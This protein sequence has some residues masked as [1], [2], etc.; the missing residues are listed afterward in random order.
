MTQNR[1]TKQKELETFHSTTGVYRL[2]TSSV[3]LAHQASIYSIIQSIQSFNLLNVSPE[4]SDKNLKL[5]EWVGY[6]WYSEGRP[7]QSHY[8]TH[9]FKTLLGRDTTGQWR[10]CGETQWIANGRHIPLNKGRQSLQ[11]GST[12]LCLSEEVSGWQLDHV[13][14]VQ[15]VKVTHYVI[16]LLCDVSSLLEDCKIKEW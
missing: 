4:I 11:C 16:L 8:M 9:P 7:R 15:P 6:S 14:I 3:I 2:I 12:L 10:R 13:L 5:R 1:D